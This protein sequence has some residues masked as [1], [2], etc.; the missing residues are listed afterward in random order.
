[1]G[2]ESPDL[3]LKGWLGIGTSR[4]QITIP[5]NPTSGFDSIA[6]AQASLLVSNEYWTTGAD[7]LGPDAARPRHAY[8][9]F[10][11][12]SVDRFVFGGNRM[13]GMHRSGA[14]AERGATT[15]TVA[16]GTSSG[17]KIT[18][19]Q[20]ATATN[21]LSAENASFETGTGT[22][23][24]NPNATVEQSSVVAKHGT[25]SLL[26]TWAGGTTQN[27]NTVL[28]LDT[29]TTYTLSAY[30][31][32]PTGSPNVR[33]SI[34]EVNTSASMTTK[35]AWTKMS[36][37]FTPITELTEITFEPVP[38]DSGSGQ[39]WLDAVL[40]ETGAVAHEHGEVEVY[41]NVPAT[42][43]AV[44]QATA[45][46]ALVATY[47]ANDQDS[48]GAVTVA[49]GTIPVAKYNGVKQVV[50]ACSAAPYKCLWYEGPENEPDLRKNVSRYA[51]D[52]RMFHAAVKAANPAAKVMGPSIVDIGNDQWGPLADGSLG[53]VSALWRWLT[54]INANG[55]DSWKI[56]GPVVAAKDYIDAVMV[57]VYN[58]MI[59]D[60]H[61]GF[62]T[63]D[64]F[65]EVLTSAGVEHMPRWQ[66]E[67]GV[68]TPVY[69]VYHPRRARWQMLYHLMLERY[70]I[71]KERN[72]LWYDKSHGFWGF[73][74]WWMNE[75]QSL[76]PHAQMV[77]VMAEMVYG[78]IYS[79][80]MD[81]GKGL[82][83]HLFMGNVYTG[84]D[85]TSTLA[86]VATSHLDNATMVL[87]L[88]GAVPSSVTWRDGF[89]K[90]T[91][92]N[93]INGEITVGIGGLPTWVALPAGCTATVKTF[94]DLN[95]RDA[96]NLAG[97]D[98]FGSF[99]GI[100][101]SRLA[102]DGQWQLTYDNNAEM[103]VGAVPSNYTVRFPVFRQVSHVIIY[104][105]MGW[106]QQSTLADFDIQT[107]TNGGGA[108]TTRATVTKTPT[109]MLHGAD[110]HNTGTQRDTFWDEQW[111]FPV[112]LPVPQDCNAIRIVVRTTSHGGEPDAASIT[113][114]GQGASPAVT[115][116]EVYVLSDDIRR[117]ASL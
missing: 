80:P 18:F 47:R 87:K 58:F 88:A 60:I 33:L 55:A 21:L 117:V 28:E 24:W 76:N 84:A 44:L 22:W 6:N 101:G 17:L 115:L 67:F 23:G 32:V 99:D 34:P 63:M 61:T 106:Q 15:V 14:V 2:G 20:G 108:W 62:H 78:K 49:S 36:V 42:V 51:H 41:D 3:A 25:K 59:T 81:F 114:G 40:V 29:A 107:S 91:V 53:G 38:V 35:N 64:K 89:G 52:A 27:T 110:S 65:A 8:I 54:G 12:D 95:N 19:N 74:G 1:V 13:Y 45:N 86:L 90:P 16:A 83:P 92:V 82:G 98:S 105:G 4:L 79:G 85:D 68:L 111:V 97:L 11:A 103:S 48:N 57:H 31:Y 56:D 46:S 93:P 43:T 5:D 9:S 10:P 73:P 75:D 30:A 26:C 71:P 39:A 116:T 72:N 112:K 94:L 69:G 102:V 66:G 109:S 100:T 104:A 50:T 77:R 113:T 96:G 7:A 37:T 70:G